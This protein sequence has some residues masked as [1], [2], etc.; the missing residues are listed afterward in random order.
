MT[1]RVHSLLDGH[2]LQEGRGDL[3][4]READGLAQLI[5]GTSV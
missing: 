3:R 4:V 5:L 1:W 2:V